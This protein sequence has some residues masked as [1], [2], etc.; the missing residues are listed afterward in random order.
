MRMT[1]LAAAA[2][3]LATFVLV[4]CCVLAMAMLAFG[5]V[6]VKTVMM[7][8][9]FVSFL[10]VLC[11]FAS[12]THESSLLSA[13]VNIGCILARSDDPIVAIAIKS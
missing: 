5:F 1:N 10:A 9:A 11:P 2:V 6:Q 12:P 4:S 7:T 13:F 3:L 8:L